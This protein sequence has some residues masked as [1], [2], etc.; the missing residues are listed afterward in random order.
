MNTTLQTIW[1]C[2]DIP[3]KEKVD[4]LAFKISDESVKCFF[5]QNLKTKE[6]SVTDKSNDALT[7]QKILKLLPTAENFFVR[8]RGQE[9][10]PVKSEWDEARQ[11]L[12]VK[13]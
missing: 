7:L 4:F 12:V 13:L 8:F 3:N 6:I 1:N 10:T 9:P 5:R 2:L 11:K